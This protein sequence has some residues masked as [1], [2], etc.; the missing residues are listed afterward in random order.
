MELAAP[1]TENEVTT[2]L[3]V[4]GLRSDAVFLFLSGS[5]GAAGKPVYWRSCAVY[6][7]E[8]E[9]TSPIELYRRWAAKLQWT[10]AL[11][12]KSFGLDLFRLRQAAHEG[13][14]YGLVTSG[15]SKPAL[16]ELIAKP[17]VRTIKIVT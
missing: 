8:C 1:M 13:K 17:G 10:D 14:I 4:R 16:A 3:G 15:Y 5:R 12:L 7:T 11:S 9:N 2:T 6:G